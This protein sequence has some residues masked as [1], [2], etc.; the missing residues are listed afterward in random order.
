[1]PAIFESLAEGASEDQ[2]NSAEL[3]IGATFPAPLRLIYR[4]HNGQKLKFDSQMDSQDSSHPPCYTSIFL[5]LFG[6]YQLY[7]H[8]ACVR[9][10]P[11]ARLVNYTQQFAEGGRL[12][13]NSIMFAADF[14]F[15]KYFLVSSVTGDVVV[16][17]LGGALIPACPVTPTGGPEDGALRWMEHFAEQLH[18]GVFRA[19]QL[20]N[21]D[22]NSRGISLFPCFGPGS[23]EEVTRGVRVQAGALLVPEKSRGTEEAFFCYSIKFSM[24]SEDEQAVVCPNLAPLKFAQLKSRHWEIVDADNDLTEVRGEAV[25]GLYPL[26]KRGQPPFE[27]QSGT[28]MKS[29]PGKMKGDFRFVPGSIESP[30]GDEFDVLCATFDLA[31]PEFVI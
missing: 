9:M 24:L 6:G 23:S 4:I 1:M 29:M 12:G 27:Y 28:P 25:I 30:T 8:L 3:T 14:H 20:L 19:A 5:G 18:T 15:K 13:S 17:T 10:L 11:L 7:D 22:P 16:N 31:M 26:V 21:T 2:I